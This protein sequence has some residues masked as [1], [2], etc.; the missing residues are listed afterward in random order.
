NSSRSGG[1]NRL[2]RRL[3]EPASLACWQPGGRRRSPTS[4]PSRPTPSFRAARCSGL[5]ACALCCRCRCSR[6]TRVVGVIG[7]DRQEVRPSSDKQIELLSIF[8][9]QAVIAIE[10][11]RLLNE[12]RES[13]QQQIATAEVLQIISR[14][15]GALEPVF[16]AMLTNAVRICE[17]K[18]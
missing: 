14:S 15:P 3:R 11:P 18:F 2:F 9:R 4:G 5:S 12:L 16:E 13:L 8:A 10:N 6:T 7:T 17:A 1:A